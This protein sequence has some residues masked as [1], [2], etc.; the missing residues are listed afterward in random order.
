M[1]IFSYKAKSHDGKYQTG[2]IESSSISKAAAAIREHGLFVITIV[3]KGEFSFRNLIPFLNRISDQD[4]ANFTRHLSTML[5][6]GL[7]L[8]DSLADLEAQP[9]E[10]FADII[11]QIRKDVTGGTSL[12]RALEKHPQ[13][14][15]PIYISMVKAGEVSGQVDKTLGRLAD[16]L[17][18]D[19]EFK[20]KVKG[21]MIYP[22]IVI[23]AMIGVGGLMMTFVVPTLSEVYKSFDSD[24]P[25]PTRIL[26]IISDF[27]RNYFP[28][29]LLGIVL[30]VIALRSFKQTKNG[31]Y[32]LNNLSFKIPIFGELNKE[33]LFATLTRTMGTLIGSGIAILDA[34]NISKD[35]IGNNQFRDTMDQAARQV[36]KGFPLSISMRN[37]AL[38]P[39][40]FAQMIAI[41]E[42]TGTMDKSLERLAGFFERNAERKIKNLTTALEPF[43]V[44]VLG[45]AVG[46]LAIAVLM[47]MFNLVNVI[48]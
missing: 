46:G 8:T 3:K 9:N 16:N 32:V 26:I 5:E 37:S 20:G 15:R 24:L 27:T 34:I 23:V 38:Y 13:V 41:G 19:I 2:V 7:P 42:E 22:A 48:K 17:E 30:G 21:A 44:I 31:D 11:S 43:L 10:L 35:I 33:V 29:V 36:E 14:F 4:L 47:P 6:T 1:P 25:L 12:S 40:I 39:P 18:K 28:L 45:V